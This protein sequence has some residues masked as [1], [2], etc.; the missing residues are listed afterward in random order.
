MI[1]IKNI[2][3]LMNLSYYAFNRGI[4]GD[5]KPQF[6]DDGTVKTTFCNLAMQYI[7]NGFG[8]GS[9]NGMNANQMVEF[10]SDYK[11]GW[12]TNDDQNAQLR[13]NEG[14]LVIAGR[15][16]F[17]SHGHVCLIIPGILEKSG[18]YGKAVP[19]CIN[20]GRDVFIGKKVSYAFSAAEAP[21]YFALGGMI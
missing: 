13:A 16:N 17:S 15:I 14:V 11:N 3:L 18:S 12:I 9:M 1:P 20:V 19:K 10:M 2:P 21:T 8:Y 4:D 5:F 7:L 6:D